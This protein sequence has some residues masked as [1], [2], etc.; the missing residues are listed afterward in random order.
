MATAKRGPKEFS[1]ND[2]IGSTCGFYL[3]FHNAE[4]Y[5]QYN[6]ITGARQSF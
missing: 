6:G 2:S 4:P 3:V 5:I 1:R